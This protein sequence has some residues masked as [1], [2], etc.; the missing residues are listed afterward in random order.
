MIYIPIEIQ[1]RMI[2][3]DLKEIKEF[4]KEFYLSKPLIYPDEC[5]CQIPISPLIWVNAN[6]A[7]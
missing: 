4:L 2:N 5:I 7:L 3:E 6:I 1:L